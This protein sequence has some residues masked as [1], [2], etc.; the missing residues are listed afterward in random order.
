M[1]TAVI[2]VALLSAASAGAQTRTGSWW[3]SHPA[4]RGAMR[5]ACQ[6]NIG[7]SR[8]IPNCANAFQGDIIAA[9]RQTSMHTF[10]GD[11]RRPDYWLDPRNASQRRFYRL[12]WPSRG[13]AGST[14]E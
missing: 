5:N 6:D 10:G 3:A 11:P 13:R 9:E 14:E 1:R 7:Q 12:P 8:H 2:L 4:E